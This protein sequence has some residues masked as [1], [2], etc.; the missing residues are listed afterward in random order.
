MRGFILI[1]NF[2]FSPIIGVQVCPFNKG[3]QFEILDVGMREKDLQQYFIEIFFENRETRKFMD[4]L[5]LDCRL[6]TCFKY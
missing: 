5:L 2:L 1:F 6:V 4:N 3:T